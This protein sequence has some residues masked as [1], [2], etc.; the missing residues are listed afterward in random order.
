MLKPV[1]ECAEVPAGEELGE[2]T[3]RDFSAASTED[4]GWFQTLVPADSQ[5]QMWHSANINY[6]FLG[7]LS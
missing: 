1:C 4:P 5:L 2:G 6:T 7:A 3:E